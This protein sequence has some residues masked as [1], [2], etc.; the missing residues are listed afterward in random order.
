MAFA[1]KSPCPLFKGDFVQSGFFTLFFG[2]H[3][4]K[5]YRESNSGL[6]VLLFLIWFLFFKPYKWYKGILGLDHKEKNLWKSGFIC[7]ES[8]SEII[9]NKIASLTREAIWSNPGMLI[10]PTVIC[11]TCFLISFF[12]MV[13][14]RIPSLYW[15]LML[16]MSAFS[17]GRKNDLWKD[18]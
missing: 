15:A 5:P 16:S 9:E 17:S 6:Y 4:Y 2:L 3:F 10:Y 12:G 18:A 1:K 11:L 14:N 13:T 8:F 7:G